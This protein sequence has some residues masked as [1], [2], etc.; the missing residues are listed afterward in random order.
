M[1]AMNSA[2][3]LARDLNTRIKIVWVKDNGLNANFS[4][5]FNIPSF[6]DIEIYEP[7]FGF[8][9]LPYTMRYG[10]YMNMIKNVLRIKFDKVFIFN[11]LKMEKIKPD[12]IK[13]YNKI[14]ITSYSSD[15][16][17]CEFDSDLFIPVPK[18]MYEINELSSR[19]GN[20]TYGIHIRK[21][22]NKES[23]H[24]SPTELFE[25]KIDVI[26]K[27]D[28]DARFY[29]ATDSIKDKDFLVQKYG[30]RIITNYFDTSRSSPAGIGNAVIDMFVLSRT[31]KIIGSYW[32]SFSEVA[33]MLG[34]VELEQVKKM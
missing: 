6:N 3:A 34:K 26:I 4:D 17:D 23:S 25:K 29:L 28:N 9:N 19:C 30:E 12:S 1:R 14:F 20:Q 18:L 16:Y 27:E 11:K 13:K 31:K 5:L 33:A 15:F 2:V 10:W 7:T 24:Y 32:S 8:Y 22:D 21:Q